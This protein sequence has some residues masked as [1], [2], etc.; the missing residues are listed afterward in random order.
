[1]GKKVTVITTGPLYEGEVNYPKG[2]F[3]EVDEERAKALGDA[4]RMPTEK[5]LGKKALS[6]RAISDN[7][8][9]NRGIKGK[10]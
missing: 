3:I 5:E 10:K 8:I 7:D 9:E 6:E 2:A 1:V 4:V